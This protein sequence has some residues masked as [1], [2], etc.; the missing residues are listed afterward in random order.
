[1]IDDFG[2]LLKSKYSLEGTDQED[3]E[4]PIPVILKLGQPWRSYQG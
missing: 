3:G 4:W 1:M 2:V